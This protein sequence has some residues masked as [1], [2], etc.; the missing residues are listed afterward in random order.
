MIDP[1]NCFKGGIYF[2]P[3]HIEPGTTESLTCPVNFGPLGVCPV[4]A[5]VSKDLEGG[6]TTTAEN[7]EGCLMVL[8]GK[9]EKTISDISVTSLE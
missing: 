7:T 6:I 9:A 1:N 8:S 5:I 3:E 4:R 2:R